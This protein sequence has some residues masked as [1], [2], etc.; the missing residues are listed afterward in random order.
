VPNDHLPRNDG[1]VRPVEQAPARQD[2][3]LIA[4][5]GS[6]FLVSDLKG[7]VAAAG[8]ARGFFFHDM[9]HISRWR[10]TSTAGRSTS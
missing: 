3:E 10:L 8:L 7:D 9:R 4:L 2:A 6:T 5:D 1:D